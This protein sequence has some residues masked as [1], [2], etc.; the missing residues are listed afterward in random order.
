MR[1]LG[2]GSGHTIE[3]AANKAVAD[4]IENLAARGREFTLLIKVD[5]Q[6][7]GMIYAAEALVEG[8]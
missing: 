5:V 6:P 8:A 4:A 1:V 3:D 2:V 7:S